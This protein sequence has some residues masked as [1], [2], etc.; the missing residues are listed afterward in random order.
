MNSNA[1]NRRSAIP[2][3]IRTRSISSKTKAGAARETPK[4]L[5]AIGYGLSANRQTRVPAMGS[6]I[7]LILEL[8]RPFEG[9]LQISSRPVANAVA[10]IL[11][12]G[13]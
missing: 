9:V 8:D 2:K 4:A 1:S 7:F 10:N 13:R 5:A 11:P 12:E 6:A 3:T